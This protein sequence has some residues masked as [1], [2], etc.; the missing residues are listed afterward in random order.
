MICIDVVDSCLPRTLPRLTHL[1]LRRFQL[2][3]ECFYRAFEEEV[4]DTI[5]ENKLFL[6]GERIAVAASGGKDSTVLAHVMTTL[7]ARYG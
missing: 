5:V 2:C 1:V 7:N 4:H 6:P 3:R